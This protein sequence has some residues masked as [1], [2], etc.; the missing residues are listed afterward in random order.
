MNKKLKSFNRIF[1]ESNESSEILFKIPISDLE[2][3][4]SLGNEFSVSSG[5]YMIHLG[6]SSAD[7]LFSQNFIVK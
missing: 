2:R 1:L 3:W 5:Q 4:D 6:T 7:L